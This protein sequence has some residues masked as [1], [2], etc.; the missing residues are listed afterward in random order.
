MSAADG[1]WLFRAVLP[2][3]FDITAI[4]EILVWPGEMEVETQFPPSQGLTGGG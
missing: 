3:L 1:L 4:I 2:W